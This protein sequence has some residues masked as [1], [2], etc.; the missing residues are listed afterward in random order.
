[1]TVEITVF[2]NRKTSRGVVRPYTWEDL[3]DRLR[4]PV[5]TDETVEEYRA[6]TNEQRTDVKDV[7]GFVGGHMKDGVRSKIALVNRTLLT[8]DADDA[9]PTTV[10]DFETINDAVFCCHTT[11]TSTEDSLRLRWVFPLSRPVTPEEYKLIAGEICKWVGVETIDETT[12]QPERLMFWPSVSFDADFR[13]WEGGT[14]LLDPD[15]ILDGLDTIPAVQTPQKDTIQKTGEQLVVPEGNRNKTVFSFAATLRGAGLDY[16]GIRSMVSDYNE[17]YC[18]TPLPEEE[19]D[20]ICRS[21]CGRYSPGASVAVTLRDAWDDFNDLGEWKESKPKKIEKLQ[22]ESMASLALRYIPPQKFVVP[23]LI[24]SGLTILASPPKFGKSWMCLDLAISVATGTEFMGIE[25]N[26]DGVIYLALED[27]DRRLQE[28]GK[29]VA[30]GRDLPE[31]LILVKEAPILADGLLPQLNAM[32]EEA[33][34]SVGMIIID[35][36]QKVR[37]PAGKTEGVYGYDYRELGQ[38][39]QFALDRDVALVIV[40]HLNKGGDDSDFVS[41][42]NGSTGVSGAADSIITLTRTSRGS[43]ETKMSITGRDVQ[44]RVLIIQMD[45]SNYRWIL[46]GDEKDVERDREDIDFRADPLV[47]TVLWGLADAEDALLADEEHEYTEVVWSCTSQDLMDSAKRLFGKEYDS[48]VVVGRLLAKL[49][50]PLEE[51]EGVHYEYTRL[52]K[53]RKR[54]HVFT[55]EMI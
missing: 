40:H 38:L 13:F 14:K 25:T 46:L 3:K 6:M 9:T 7:G 36:L 18:T 27:G 41:R 19:L 15:E 28:R 32:V 43:D 26:R 2:K 30:N 51:K 23:G 52:G 31:N 55:R 17:R 11:H 35:T 8:I 37:G 47:K 1:M 12:D 45:W 48:T 49:A 5:V 50:K 10:A 44:E 34:I 53:D 42:L 21:V 4:K 20:T 29:K 54:T 39:Q 24:P 33:G 22:G 16:Q